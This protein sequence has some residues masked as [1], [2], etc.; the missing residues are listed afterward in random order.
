MLIADLTSIS[1]TDPLRGY[2][3]HAVWTVAAISIFCIYNK[4]T[5][6]LQKFLVANN[7]CHIRYQYAKYPSS[8]MFRLIMEENAS[9]VSTA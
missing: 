1:Q 4:T 3:I 5:V 8:A 7:G 2:G 9:T 6:T